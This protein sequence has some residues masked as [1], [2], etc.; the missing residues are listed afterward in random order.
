MWGT[1]M[2]GSINRAI[3]LFVRDSYGEDTWRGCVARV[4]LACSEFEP[5]LEYPDQV[6]DD[7]LADLS[8]HLG[9][10]TSDVLEDIGTYLV[11]HPTADPVRRLLRFS[12]ADFLEFL[13]SIDE[14]PART[15]LVMSDLD[16]PEITLQEHKDQVFT[17]CV[18]DQHGRAEWY[19]HVLMGLLRAMAD[20]Y[21]ALVL[22]DHKGGHAKRAIVDVDLALASF[23][24][25]R[26]FAL[27]KA[28]G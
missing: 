24:E 23:S 22:L 19:S 14:L 2:H 10:S 4:G 20:D 16:I 13:N 5:L 12:G 21:G 7:L 27:G 25:G 26:D 1:G 8:K 28:I 9:K 15:Q 18:S 17:V 3:E 11:S 6:T